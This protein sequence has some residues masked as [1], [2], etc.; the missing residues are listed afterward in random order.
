MLKKLDMSSVNTIIDQARNGVLPLSIIP[1]ASATRLVV[2]TPSLE[3]FS[4]IRQENNVHYAGA[5]WTIVEVKD[6]NGSH[7]HLKEVT[8]ANELNLTWPLSITCERTTKLQNNEIMPGKLKER[9]VK[10]SAILDG[11]AFG[12]GK[13]LMAAESG[14]SFM[15][16]FIASDN[17]LKYVKWESNNDI[18]PIE[19]EAPLRFY[20]DGVNGPE[21]KYLYFVKNLNTLRRGAVLG[22]IGATVRL[23]AGKPTEH[24]SNSSLLTLCAFAPDP[25]KAYVDAVK[26]G[27]QPVNN[28]VKM[29]SNGAGNGMAVTN[30]VEANTQQDS[31]GGASVC[32]YCRCH[33][34][35]PAIDGMCRYKGKF[36]Q[37]PTGTQDPIRFV[38]KM[39]FV[40]SVAVGLTMVACAIVLLCRVLLLIKVI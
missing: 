30:G 21:V 19:L 3:V 20:V 29:L 38:L 32:I 39:K 10:A 34:E 2:V 14:K 36:V 28:C 7:V 16:A 18:I 4:R 13:A 5:I 35:H 12:S 15:Y 27:M 17:N 33:V 6:A 8:A 24:P 11:E 37:I 22:Y 1:A 23:Q 40:L 9:A 26:R 25:A 31:Y